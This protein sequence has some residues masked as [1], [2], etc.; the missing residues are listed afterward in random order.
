[1]DNNTKYNGQE[2]ECKGTAPEAALPALTN[3]YAADAHLGAVSTNI[4]VHTTITIVTITI[5]TITA[6]YAADAHLGALSTN[7]TVHT[8]ITITTTTTTFTSVHIVPAVC[9]PGT[10]ILLPSK[11]LILKLFY[12]F[13]YL[14]SFYYCVHTEYRASNN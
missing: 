13:L 5:T 2:T 1:M 4:T 3:W 14:Q 11:Q 10:L 9:A 8:T 6:H 12:L 7:I